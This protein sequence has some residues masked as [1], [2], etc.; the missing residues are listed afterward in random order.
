MTP[1]QQLMLGV[2]ASEKIYVDEVFSNY[3]WNGN[4]AARS[5]DN[6]INLSESGGMTWI[7]KRNDTDRN[8]IT[9]T[10]RGKTKQLFTERNDPQQTDSN[11]ITAFNTNG[12][13]LGTDNRINKS[14]DKYTSQTFR[15]AEGFFDV[16]EYSGNSSNRTIA[17]SL[18]SIPGMILI[19]ELTDSSK[20]IVY[21]RSI[22]AANILSL[23]ENS[24]S[25]SGATNFNSTV[26]T[27][28]HFSLGG[29]SHVNGSSQTYVAYLF[30]GGES[31]ST[32]AASVQYNGNDYNYFNDH[33]DFD[34]G[35]NFTAECW[36]KANSIPSGTNYNVIMG[37][38][39]NSN[40]WVFEYVGTTL[41]FYY[42]SSSNYK[43]LGTTSNRAGL[44]QWHHL[45]F[46]KQG[47]TT[48]IF[49]DGVQVVEDFDMG[50]QSSSSSFKIGGHASGS[51]TTD[52]CFDGWISNV[53]VVKDT[54]VYTSSFR[55]PTEPLTG[56]T[57][58]V[59]L[60]NNDPTNDR[61]TTV[62]TTGDYNYGGTGQSDPS[63]KTDSPFDDPAGFVFGGKEN[64]IKCNSYVGNGTNSDVDVYLGWEPQWIMV[65][66]TGSS[67]DWIV[68]D[69][70]RGIGAGSNE[71]YLYA[72]GN[73]AEYTAADR[74]ELTSTGFKVL[75]ATS[76]S[77][78]NTDGTEYSYIAIRRQDGYVTKPI[79]V[80]THAFTLVAGNNGY[81]S[82]PTN[83]GS[84]AGFPVDFA[85]MRQPATSQACYTGAR[86]VGPH[87]L[88][89]TSDAYENG[90]ADSN[91]VFDRS[92]GW[93]NSYPSSYQSWIWRRHA[94]MDVVVYKGNG[95]AGR[96]IPHSMSQTP[97]MLWVKKRRSGTGGA[98]W[99]VYHKGLNGGTN[100]EQYYILLNGS[101]ADVDDATIWNDTAPTKTHFTLGTN[102]N[103]NQNGDDYIA[104]LFASV[105]GI[106][107]VGYFD[108]S[109]SSHTIVTGFQPRWAL[110]KNTSGFAQWVM[111]DTL[112]GWTNGSQD[113]GLYLSH[114]NAHSTSNIGHPVSNGLYLDGDNSEI[115]K[116]G[117]T[118]IYYTHA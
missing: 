112:R 113:Y 27:S 12:F 76:W 17:H 32:G 117:Q 6:G 19:K 91:W 81:P 9:D 62:N 67:D 83:V 93:C 98:N 46:S 92:N 5:I 102:S 88:Q 110:F 90:S 94:G 14:G 75:G 105:P 43:N 23:N 38:W 59:I 49:L 25:T 8:V 29:S 10:G 39:F 69:S 99:L 41:R 71:A 42:G 35:T 53:R 20:W 28:T 85:L 63:P 54:A 45:A 26:P 77:A 55:V 31:T 106:S 51:G 109:D 52:G 61:A 40:A 82:F 18:A 96:A 60:C 44:G 30:A 108:G 4:G 47:T 72:N 114:N 103:V 115:S 24:S 13:S 80:G 84:Y 104:I 73:G 36:F 11:Y 101:S 116:A 50:T 107:S 1:I 15:K 70:M 65:K 37:Q 86:L 33:A 48:R 56:I 7:K 111:A 87:Y 16:V 64:I 100:P 118:H 34:V 22:G 68:F 97:E 79:E 3:L 21:H 89:T 78:I 66:S 95:M 74:I 58:T 2:G 57:N